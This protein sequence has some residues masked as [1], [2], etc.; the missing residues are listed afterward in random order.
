[1]AL[2]G[3]AS[4][5]S[6]VEW[7]VDSQWVWSIGVGVSQQNLTTERTDTG[8]RPTRKPRDWSFCRRPFWVFSHLFAASVIV[9]FVVLGFW[10]LNRLQER[11]AEN[12][13]I[14]ARSFG[15]PELMSSLPPDVSD[16]DY[17]LVQLEATFVD[18]DFVRVANRSQGG[19]A[20]EWVIGIVRFE[21]GT[22][23][24]IN[25]GFVPINSDSQLTAVPD[26]ST[27]LTGWLRQSVEREWPGVVDAG[28]GDVLPRLDTERVSF[29]LGRELPPVWLQLRPEDQALASFPDP[30]PLPP[31]NEGSHRSY[32][33]QWFIFAALGAGFYAAVVFRRAR[34]DAEAN[35]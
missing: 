6:S 27:R 20:G 33:V 8:N 10:Q 21:D 25:R 13:I 16:L 29:R 4:R 3:S 22:D 30:V 5:P 9:T 31:L 32:A 23:V 26:Q 18:E 12:E 24:A 28:A 35:N 11:R 19:V 34:T 2:L 14:A 15:E 7:T 1:M 17:R